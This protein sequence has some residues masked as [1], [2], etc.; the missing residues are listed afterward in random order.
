MIDRKSD[1]SD[2]QPPAGRSRWVEYG[3]L[4]ATCMLV[5]AVYAC[6]A[7]SGYLASTSLNAAD[8]YYNLLVKGFQAGQLNLKTDVPPGLA[9]AADPYDPAVHSRYPLLD[10]SYYKGKLYLYFGVTPALLLFWPYAALTGDYLVQKDAAVVFCLVGF[11]VSMGLLCAVWRRYFAEISVGVVAA[12]VLALGLAIGTPMLLARCDVYEVSISCGYALTMLALGGIWKAMHHPSQR[13]RWLAAASLA[14][15]LALGARPSLLFGAA[16]L[17]VPVVQAWRERRKFGVALL[18][19]TGPMMLIGLGLMLYNWRRFDNPFEFGFRYALAGDRL[20]TRQPFS[21]RH[22]WFNFRVYFLGLARWNGRF[23]FVHGIAV[24]SLPAG[25]GPVEQT[26]GV[27]TNIPLVWLALAVPLAWRNRS[28]EARSCLKGFLAAAA[29]LF[30]IGALTLGLYYYTAGRFEVEFLPALV[31]LAVIGILSLERAVVCQ[32]LWRRATRWGW[33]LLLGFSVA[34]NLLASVERCAE[35]DYNFGVALQVAGRMQEAMGQYEQ[36]LRL[37]P[38]NAE[39]HNSLGNAL[40]NAGR[41]QEAIAH[42]EEALRLKPDLVEVQVNLAR[43]RA[44]Q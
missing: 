11:M 10:M 3:V 34:F 28:A 41:M 6:T 18:A 14:Y 16:V 38:D 4:A 24:P 31:L 42:Y 32:P 23:P 12:G 37:K 13:G 36:A 33:S 19:A 7:H 15:G 2:A 1:C 17:L 22:L 27:L 8:S 39:A 5:I 26:F 29:L 35:A 20:L 40:A 43:A 44:A 25:H 30:W 9:Q 21:L